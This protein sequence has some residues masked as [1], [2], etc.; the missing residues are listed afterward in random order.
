MGKAALQMEESHEPQLDSEVVA[1]FQ[2]IK[3]LFEVDFVPEFFKPL[4]NSPSGL[5]G[6]WNIYKSTLFA[7]EIPRSI[8]ELIF[9][10]IAIQNKCVYCTSIHMAISHQMKLPEMTD[11]LG[12]LEN[13]KNT[14]LRLILQKALKSVNSPR[15]MSQQDYEEL[16]EASLSKSEIIEVF[17]M[18]SFSI[19]VVKLAQSLK[20]EV[21]EQVTKYLN[22]NKLVCPV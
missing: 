14:R 11:L 21:D 16:E 10:A 17:G 2:E 15:S 12:G 7:G 3:D 1:T 19:S 4:A 5:R 20:V 18:A 22:E 9:L 8:K 13:V 6:I